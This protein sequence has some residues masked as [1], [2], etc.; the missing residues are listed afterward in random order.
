MVYRPEHPNPQFE[1]SSYRC[2]NGIWGFEIG[3]PEGRI[4]RE[5]AGSIVV[6]FCPE[7]ELSGI[8]LRDFITDC[9]YTREIEVS[10]E[11]LEGRLVLHFGAVDYLTEV[12]VN[13][14]FVVRHIGGYTPFEADIAPFAHV[15]ANRITVCVHDDV[16]ENTASGKQS[17]KRESFGCF[18]TRTT[19]IWQTVWLER[20]PENY[21]KNV[22]FFPDAEHGSVGVEVE[23]AG[24]GV[25]SVR[26][27]YEG[28]EVAQAEAD[29]DAVCKL[30]LPL[31]VKKLWEPGAGRLYDVE[32]TFGQDRVK[33]Y[34]GL[35]DVKYSGRKFLLNGK[36]VFQRLVLDQGYYSDGIYTAPN[37]EAIKDDIRISMSLGFNGARPH[38]KLFEPRY[39]YECD[40]AGY[41]VWGE[42]ASWGILYETLDSLEQFL[43]E[44]KEAVLRDFNHPCIVQWCPLNEAWT[45]LEDKSKV[46]DIRFVES[47]YAYTKRLDPT[48][49]CVDTSGGYHGRHTDLFDFHC[50]H[51]PEEIGEYI[52][53]I[54]EK[55]ELIMDTLYPAV[56]EEGAMYDGNLPL[57]ASEFG[58][59]AYQPHGGVNGVQ[60]AETCV[61]E[62]SAWGYRVCDS[63]SD[64]ADLYV[65]AT[66]QLLACKKISG[67]CYTQLYD[68]E[69]EQNGLFTYEREAKLSADALARIAACNRR[70]A[71]IE[72]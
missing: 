13:G 9:V 59:V 37:A 2:L 63:E 56:K 8:G 48:R 19:G 66:E 15:G 61:R 42:Y 1:R 52:K 11:D 54:E 30:S 24:R 71:A 55:G 23:T 65:R 68:V 34:F 7:S 10:R 57:N 6:P 64:F 53:A 50:Y 39:L 21:I 72:E 44:W 32:L 58:G 69:Q 16:R 29:A 40:K 49:P 41:M 20:T 62:R 27:C 70:R 5:L 12:Y 35:R 47:V 17:K 28:K 60:S 14:S 18:Y 4:G 25:L 38:Q 26:V 46:R 43:A 45:N 36:S 31:A 51:S 33:S 67:F 3:T 22:K